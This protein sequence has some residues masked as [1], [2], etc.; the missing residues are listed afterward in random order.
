MDWWGTTSSAQV[1]WSI[2]ALVLAVFALA[3]GLA[4]DAAGAADAQRAAGLAALPRRAGGLGRGL[5]RRRR[6][7]HGASLA[8]AGMAM[9]LAAYAAAF[10]EPA[11][12]V[13]LR[14]FAGLAVRG[15]AAEA[16]RHRAGLRSSRWSS[17][18]ILTLIGFGV[19][20]GRAAPASSRTPAALLAFLVRDLGVIALFRFGPRP[21]RGDFGAV[22]ALAVLYGVGG[23]FGGSMGGL[24]RAAAV[25]VPTGGDLA[26]LSII[27][28]L[29]QAVVA[30]V[31]AA[32]RIRSPETSAQRASI[33]VQHPLQRRQLVGLAGRL[34]PADAADAREA[35]G[36]AGLV[37]GGALQAL[38]G[39]LEAPGPRAARRGPS[40]PARSA[41]WCCRGRTCRS[42]SAPRR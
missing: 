22:M 26:G 25:F 9:C 39:D 20:A 5:P 23:I 14:R 40:A 11:D 18:L 13:A 32:R 38:E 1:F 36:D 3:G 21:Q 41:R 31:L 17:P 15:E 16:A 28:G 4:A 6:L 37:A 7:G 30:W 12:R 19:P 42:A 29:V 10:A 2:S 34:V 24:D 35:H 8:A 27:S 33:C